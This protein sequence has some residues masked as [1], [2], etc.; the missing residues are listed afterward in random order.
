MESPSPLE[1]EEETT[2]VMIDEADAF[3]DPSPTQVIEEVLDELETEG[4]TIVPS[5]ATRKMWRRMRMSHTSLWLR[6]SLQ[7]EAIRRS[8]GGGSARGGCSQVAPGG[9]RR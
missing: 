3:Y 7:T 6:K 5:K 9:R 1:L 2:A 4:I 8:T